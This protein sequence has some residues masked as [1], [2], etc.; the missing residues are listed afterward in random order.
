MRR[1]PHHAYPLGHSIVPLRRRPVHWN[2]TAQPG[3]YVRLVPG[4][5]LF[6]ALQLDVSET[7]GARGQG[8]QACAANRA[9][10]G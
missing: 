3:D 10:V 1:L 7:A 5:R 9:R 6:L 8:L 2:V 4:V